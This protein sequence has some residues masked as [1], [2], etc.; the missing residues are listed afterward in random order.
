MGRACDDREV[1]ILPNAGRYGARS[2]SL[3]R[4]V[5][6][7]TAKMVGKEWGSCEGERF[8]KLFVLGDREAEGGFRSHG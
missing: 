3:Y 2:G 7:M 4:R 6:G 1:L 8:Y 5:L